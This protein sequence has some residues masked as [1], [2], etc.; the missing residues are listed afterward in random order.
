M[1]TSEVA[2]YCN[3][4]SQNVDYWRKVKK[5]SF[6]KIDNTFYFNKDEVDKLIADKNNKNEQI[7]RKI[8]EH[9]SNGIVCLHCQK[10]TPYTGYKVFVSNHLIK[11]HNLNG[12]QYYD[13]YL[14]KDN[15]NVCAECGKEKGFISISK[16]YHE[17][18]SDLNCRMNNK[19]IKDSIMKTKMEKYGDCNYVNI[20]KAK[21]TKLN[22]YGDKNFTNRERFKKTWSLKSEEE[23]IKLRKN[24]IES[25]KKKYIKFLEETLPHFNCEIDAYQSENISIKCKDCQ[26]ISEYS[27]KHIGN[28]I[29]RNIPLCLTC[30]PLQSSVSSYEKEIIEYIKSFYDGDIQSNVRDIIGKEIDI[31]IPEKRIGIEFNGVFWHNSESKTNSYHLDKTLKCADKN[32]RLIHLFEDE[33]IH[34]KDIIKYKIRNILGYTSSKIFARKCEI[35]LVEDIKAQ[36][37]FYEQNHIQGWTFSKVS[38]G[39]YYDKVLV[40]LMSF[41][42]VVKRKKYEW[43]LVRY[44]TVRDSI[45]TGGASKL[46]KHFINVHNP[47]NIVSYADYSFSDGNLYDVLGFKNDGVSPPSYFYVDKTSLIRYHR[48]GF[49]KDALKKK[50]MIEDGETEEMAMS[51]SNYYKIYDCGKIRY[52][53]ENINAN[54][55]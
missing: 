46:L 9:L 40:A 33:W 27:T 14:I 45:V 25:K 13:M 30:H 49:R 44:A 21:E 35:H 15:E 11:E 53:W 24:T 5:L 10:K 12:K 38:Y 51:R 1:K 43:E 26:S 6:I 28:R 47:K 52:I 7:N 48:F 16:G 2:E 37:D 42:N 39:L 34:K 22:K 17:Y 32:I 19:D 20:E 18:C 36:K 41:S 4:K 50:N 23:V 31:F 8:K 54:S 3:V 29:K 55:V